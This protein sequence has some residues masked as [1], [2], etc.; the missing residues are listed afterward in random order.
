M[1]EIFDLP[2][3]L[4]FLILLAGFLTGILHGATGMAGGIVMAAVLTQL[5]GI[6]AAF[7]VMTVTLIFS[8]ASRVL[9]Y[10]READ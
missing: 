8:H 6:K 1:L 10:A 9:L 5:I 3:S 4:L 2:A 7:P